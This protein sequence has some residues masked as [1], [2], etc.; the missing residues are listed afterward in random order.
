MPE[1]KA[2]LAK[3]CSNVAIVQLSN[4]PPHYVLQVNTTCTLGSA[5]GN[6]YVILFIIMF[7]PSAYAARAQGLHMHEICFII[8]RRALIAS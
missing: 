3:T 7:L 4:R 2:R 5:L 8:S 1:D 6:F